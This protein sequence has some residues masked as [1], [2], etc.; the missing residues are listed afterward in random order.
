VVALG[1]A[2][3]GLVS[4][5]LGPLQPAA[6]PKA[7]FRL[8]AAVATLGTLLHVL[9]DLPTSYGTRLLSPFS[10][11][12][13]A[14]DWL[15]IVDIYLLGTLAA[16]LALGRQSPAARRRN[17]AIAL[18]VM[19]INYGVRGAAHERAV[20]YA[21]RLFGPLLPQRCDPDSHR[22]LL[23]SWP[24]PMRM[25]PADPSRRCLVEILALPTFVS[26]FRWRV[27][28]HLSSAYETQ[29]I[30]VL[31]ARWKRP[32]GAAEATWRTTVRFPN[33]WSA[34]VRA[35]AAS[36]VGRA[37]LGFARLPSVRTS[38]DAD[39]TATV[40]WIDVRFAERPPQA[41][42]SFARAIVRVGPDGEI[43]TSPVSR[44]P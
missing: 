22:P 20:A 1:L 38:F 42:S 28:A 6:R 43:L 35:A 40:R 44:R 19:G 26:P 3:A 32:P 18:L 15:P 2:T 27:V 21:P 37:F 30:D 7:P 34:P 4:I 9:M 8:L 14:F 5:V 12:W 23:E 41:D 10:W 39:G 25:N 16:C 31:D 11:R 24:R 29:E 13:F 33:A 36:E 17:V